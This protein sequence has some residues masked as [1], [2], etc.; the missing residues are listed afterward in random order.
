MWDGKDIPGRK[1]IMC[2]GKRAGFIIYLKSD[3]I[4]GMTL[5]GKS[6]DIRIRQ[7]GANFEGLLGKI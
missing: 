5:V 2:K 3:K 1:Y 4:L 7:A 6:R